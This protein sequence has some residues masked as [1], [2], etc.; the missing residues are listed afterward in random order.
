[1]ASP[2]AATTSMPWEANSR[3]AGLPIDEDNDPRTP[4]QVYSRHPYGLTENGLRE[5]MG[6]P[7]REAY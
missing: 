7:S 2:T 3:A 5:E 6:A 1:M 4:D